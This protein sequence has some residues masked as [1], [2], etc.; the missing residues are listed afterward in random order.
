[1]N[2]AREPSKVVS[3]SQRLDPASPRVGE[4]LNTVRTVA[5]Q[6]LQ[7]S[8]GNLFEHVDDALFDLAEKAE[9]NA[10]QMHY[11]DGMREVR[12]RR[13]AV[14]RSYLAQV[15][16]EL[17]HL[18]GPQRPNPAQAAPAGGIELSLVADNELEES[19]A[20][21]SMVSKNESRL[22]RELFAVNQ[23]L[24]VICGGIKI[25]ETG[26][27]LGP[28][29]LAQAFRQALR[30]LSAD[31]RVKLIIYKLFDRYVLATLDELYQAVNAE[32]IRAG[33]LPQLRHEV[34]RGP[35]QAARAVA[36]VAAALD[37]GQAS[38]DEVAF[39]DDLLQTLRQLFHARR[40][41]PID[42]GA[43]MPMG[44]SPVAAPTAHELLGALSVLQS[45]LVGSGPLP[46]QNQ[47]VDVAGLGEQVAQLKNQLMRQLGALRGERPGQVAS[48]D[49]DTIDLVGML[50]EFILTDR[51]LPAEM[52]AM[53]AR[54]QIPYLKAA[55]LDRR[56]F[57]HRQHPARRLLDGLADMAKSWSAEADRDHRVHDKVKSIVDQLLHDFDDD[58][59]IFERLNNDL[60]AFQEQSHKRAE[61]AEQRVA[62]STRGRERLEQARRRAAREIV[63]R[64]GEQTLP[65]LI[66]GVLA[67]AWANYM[68]LT[69][70]RQGED[71]AEYAGALR[72]VNE[73]IASAQPARD[74]ESRRTLRQM[75]PGIERALRRGLTQVAFQD[76]DI[77]RLLGQLYVYYRQ[78]LGDPVEATPSV[79]DAAPLIP[80][81]I[82]PIVERDAPVRE[83]DQQETLAV[84]PPDIPELE[85]VLALKPGTWLEFTPTGGHSERAK[86]S[87]I[88]PMSGRYLFVNRRGL[89][90]ADYAPQELAASLA[91]GSA[92]VLA[93]EPLFD[94]AMHAIVG[95]LSQAAPSPPDNA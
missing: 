85:V 22:A 58:L 65:P 73:F 62:E 40:G 90:V 89:K 4:L 3:L 29:A 52:Q 75:L 8:L 51:N 66:H 5:A 21:T 88:S 78:Q 72:F 68:V 43:A 53:L 1:M 41:Q 30:E 14:E 35:G 86:L 49:E 84:P 44:T 45:Q 56:L 15:S 28:A 57:A 59:G 61:L 71:S 19:L 64:I 63:D 23:R 67:R 20:I 10:A 34:A 87:W 95:R 24:S 82:Q 93:S 33:V 7:Q 60:Q 17:S 13:P 26:N 2:E 39:S 27:P 76:H 50:F 92:C 48:V 31:M 47:P 25:D 12:K 81:S 37:A 83:S 69:I 79:E 55:I 94:R 46:V 74:A 80:E 70:L 32:L 38:G 11:F 77:D 91:A 9:N 54:L 6:R 18:A 16:R 36:D 42:G